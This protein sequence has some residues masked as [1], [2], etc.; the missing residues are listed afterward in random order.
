[1]LPLTWASSQ[2]NTACT[3]ALIRAKADVNVTNLNETPL[4][5]AAS[6]G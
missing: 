3:L 4:L 6:G 5:C 2:G 1:M